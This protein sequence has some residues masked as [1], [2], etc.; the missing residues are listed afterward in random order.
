MLEK[1][2]LEQESLIPVIRDKWIK[3]VSSTEPCDFEKSK[4][5]VC[6]AYRSVGLKEPSEFM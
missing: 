4:E 2:T 1:L 5:A 3:I 6:L